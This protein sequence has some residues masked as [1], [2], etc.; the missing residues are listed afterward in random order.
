MSGSQT[1][2]E[3]FTN[4]FVAAVRARFRDSDLLRDGMEWVAGGVQPP[5]VATILYRDR[6]GGPVLGRR[7]PLKEY[8]AL[9]GGETV[10]WLAT[11]A[12]VSDITAPSGDGERKDVDWAEGLVP[13][14]TEVR[15]LD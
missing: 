6:P 8:S 5:D 14:P 9:F 1:V 15:W 4:E 2:D 13:D 11:E 12:W 3:A 10:Q 7:Y